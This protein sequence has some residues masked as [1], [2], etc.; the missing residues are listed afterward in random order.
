MQTYSLN[1][2]FTN[3]CSGLCSLL[4]ELFYFLRVPTF[5]ALQNFKIF[6]KRPGL[7]V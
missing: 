4:K 5:Q 6:T 7:E 3:F 1:R 2:D